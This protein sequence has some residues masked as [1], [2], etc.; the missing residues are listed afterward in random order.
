MATEAAMPPSR[1][2]VRRVILGTRISYW[3]ADTDS[4]WF[5]RPKGLFL[6][7]VSARRLTGHIPYHALFRLRRE[8]GSWLK[9]VPMK[10][11]R[12][13]LNAQPERHISSDRLKFLAERNATA[14]KNPATVKLRS[15]SLEHAG[16]EV[17]LR[18]T[19]EEIESSFGALRV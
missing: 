7:G 15:K 16:E 12:S 10:T 2:K 19:P 18:V 17:L 8:P 9:I 11:K 5:L 3:L 1:I 13:R 4:N 6:F 14:L